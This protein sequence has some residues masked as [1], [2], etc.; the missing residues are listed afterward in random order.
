MLMHWKTWPPVGARF[1]SLYGYSAIQKSSSQNL[2]TGFQF[3]RGILWWVTLYQIP[4]YVDLSKNMAVSGWGIFALYGYCANLKNLL[5]EI[6]QGI[7]M[8]Y[9]RDHSFDSRWSVK[10]R[11]RQ[12]VRHFARYTTI[13]HFQRSSARLIS[14]ILQGCS[15]S[16]SWTHSINSCWSVEKDSG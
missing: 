3:Y 14:M 5:L 7:S 1:L 15:L 6:F 12:W 9:Y 16:S 4:S 8:K 2:F 11:D 13:E 10:Q